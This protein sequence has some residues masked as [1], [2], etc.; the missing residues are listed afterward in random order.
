M[1]KKSIYLPFFITALLLPYISFLIGF[2]FY[3]DGLSILA[4]I[5]IIPVITSVFSCFAVDNALYHMLISLNQIVAFILTLSRFSA[6]TDRL[7]AINTVVDPM[8]A[9]ISALVIMVGVLFVIGVFIIANLFKTFSKKLL[10]YDKRISEAEDENAV[11]KPSL[12]VISFFAF[13]MIILSV[14]NVFTSFIFFVKYWDDLPN[15]SSQKHLNLMVYL[16]AF[17]ILLFIT[18]MIILRVVSSKDCAPL[19]TALT[20]RAFGYTFLFTLLSSIIILFSI[21]FIISGP[22]MFLF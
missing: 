21:V 20:A 12:K 18:A 11:T 19:G 16:F 3:H 14:F 6:A 7:P 2:W 13:L 15:M 8:S 5:L 22:V 10:D 1:N 17:A 9:K 4:P